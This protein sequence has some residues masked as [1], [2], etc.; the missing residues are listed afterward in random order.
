MEHHSQDDL[1]TTPELRRLLGGV[2]NMFLYRRLQDDPTFPRPFRF[3]G[4]NAPRFWS[5]A[6]IRE[7]I[8][9]HRE[10]AA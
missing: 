4:D 2:S 6:E 10:T 7:W 3:G 9:A 1:I 5:R 8:E